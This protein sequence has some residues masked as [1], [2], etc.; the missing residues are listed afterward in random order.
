M[1]DK[2]AIRSHM[3]TLRRALTPEEALERSL[4]AQ[5]HILETDEWRHTPSVGLYYA[6]RNE[7]D[8]ALLLDTA[9]ADGKE[10]YLPKTQP[11]GI[12][13]FLPCISRQALVPGIMGIPE[14]NPES[15]PL[16]PEG[17]WVPRLIIVPG[18]A[19][20]RQGHRIGMAGG[21]YDKYFSRESTQ[22]A[23][24]L[25]L[26]Y[27]FQIVDSLPADPWDAPVHAIATEEGILWL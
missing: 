20:D 8:T 21:Y 3:R 5:R 7:T 24:R 25:A 10:V 12:M 9:W 16:P 15:C 2:G 19:F 4:A 26:A 18:V 14:P 6:I 22:D 27:A 17:E 23:F 11:G 1:K 13:Q